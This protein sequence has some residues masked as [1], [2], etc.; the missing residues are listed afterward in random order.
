MSQIVSVDLGLT[1]PMRLGGSNWDLCA[2]CIIGGVL[3]M[4]RSDD[5]GLRFSHHSCLINFIPSC[6]IQSSI[7]CTTVPWVKGRLRS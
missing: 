1:G 7:K 5:D 2:S 6:F 4:F 3:V